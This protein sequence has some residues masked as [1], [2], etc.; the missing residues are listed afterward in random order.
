MPYE[1]VAVER[2]GD[3]AVLTL[4][5][6]EALN[7]LNLVML[8]ELVQALREVEESDA[9]ALVLTGEMRHVGRGAAQRIYTLRVRQ[10]CSTLR[11]RHQRGSSNRFKLFH[12]ACNPNSHE[13]PAALR[14]QPRCF[15]PGG[16]IEDPDCCSRHKP[17]Q[18][19]MSHISTGTV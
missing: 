6:P 2:S 8:R 5:R 12:L 1:T 4:N 14:A 13:N 19:H 17:S 7:A 16:G 15:G 9:S 18:R 11:N 10:S 3:V